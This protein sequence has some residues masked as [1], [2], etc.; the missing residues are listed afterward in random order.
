MILYLLAALFL[1]PFTASGNFAYD[2]YGILDTRPQT[3]GYADSQEAV[4]TFS[5]PPGA[6]RRAHV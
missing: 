6:D 4:F 1:G 3:R 5:P 2:L